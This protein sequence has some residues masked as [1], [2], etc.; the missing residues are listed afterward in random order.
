MSISKQEASIR[1]GSES[2][3]ASD[4]ALNGFFSCGSMNKIGDSGASET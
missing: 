2:D 4:G 1:Q 3:S